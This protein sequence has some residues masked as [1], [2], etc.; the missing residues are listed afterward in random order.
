MKLRALVI[1]DSALFRRVISDALS[2]LPDVEVVSTAPNG[3]IAL[4][5][6]ALYNPDLITLDIEMPEMNGLEVLDALKERGFQRGVIVVSALTL[7]GG[8]M[9]IRALE[10][11][12]FDFITKPASGDQQANLAGIRASLAP[13]VEGLRRRQE[14]RSIL[15]NTPAPASQPSRPDLAPPARPAGLSGAPFEPAAN[16]PAVRMVLIGISTGGPNALMRVLP[17][18]PADLPVPVLIVQHMPPLFTQSLASSLASRCAIAVKEAEDGEP[19]RPHT[20]YIAPGGRHMKVSSTPA[21]E[22][23]LRISDEP[24]ENNCRPS[25][26]VLFRSAANLFPGQ[27]IPIIMTGMGND[28]VLGLRLLKRHPC[29]VIAQDAESC[30]VFGMPGEAVKAGVVDQLLPLDRIADEIIR[31]TRG[32]RS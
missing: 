28:G 3:K 24:P 8:A 14:I 10:K 4:E 21:G 30:I 31:S 12:A 17:L 25:V 22:I 1:D 7:K 5:R 20:V 13:I 2:Q 23:M 9:T 16:R 32:A 15:N 26:D 19:A 6:V 11:G 29:R 27:S 18:L